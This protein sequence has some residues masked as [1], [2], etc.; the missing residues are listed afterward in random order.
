[1]QLEMI[2][3]S[4]NISFYHLGCWINNYIN[5][6]EPFENIIKDIKQNK[7]IIFGIVSGNSFYENENEDIISN[8][9]ISNGI[10]LIKKI[11]KP[12]F[13]T[14]NNYDKSITNLIDKTKFSMVQGKLCIDSTKSSWIMP[15]NYYNLYIHLINYSIHMIF[16]DTNLFNDYA[17]S[18]Y[19]SSKDSHKN[20]KLNHMLSWLEVILM[21]NTA[22]TVIIVANSAIFKYKRPDD[23]F[24]NPVNEGDDNLICMLH[25][26]KLLILLNKFVNTTKY[27]NTIYYL[28]SDI[29]NYQ[30][31]EYIGKNLYSNLKIDIIIA[32]IS[33][34]TPDPIPKLK[35]GK[36][37]LLKN[38]KNE[39]VGE[40]II[41]DKDTPYG[42]LMHTIGNNNKFSTIFVQIHDSFND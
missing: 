20:K 16:I 21:N 4:D 38:K 37:F 10:K 39:S 1:M 41:L 24:G 2:I 36:S 22:E 23:M 35:I 27:N 26:E 34:S 6:N 12:S 29:N 42:Y 25:F 15:F 3:N 17:E 30:Y 32:G 31:I 5:Y 33:G 11:G 18:Y 9:S 28:C 8:N 13:I 14:S 40:I 19:T 7:E